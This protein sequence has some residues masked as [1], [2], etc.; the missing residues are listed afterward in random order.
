MPERS[1]WFTAGSVAVVAVCAPLATT[2]SGSAQPILGDQITV[3]ASDFEPFCTPHTVDP[4]SIP[5]EASLDELSGLVSV[6]GRSYAVGDSGSDRAVA[7]LDGSCGVTGWLSVPV[8]PYDVEDLAT[9]PDGRLWLADI[10][11]NGRR[12][13]TVALIGMDRATGAGQLH[14]LT[15]PDGAHDA[16]TV[17]VQRDGTPL[18][19]TKEV[20][21]PGIVY[22][23]AGGVSVDALA[24][25]GPT[26]LERVG[27]LD[28]AEPN[29]AGNATTGAGTTAPAVYSTMFTG[30][31]VSADGT[32]AAVRS[33]TDVFLFAAPDGD[34]A[35]ALAAGPTVRVHLPAQPQGEAVAFTED[36]DLLIASEARD[37][38]I[39]PVEVLRG[40]VAMAQDH[41]SSEAA[42]DEEKSSSAG[43]S[44]GVGAVA[45]CGLIAVVA[46]ACLRRTR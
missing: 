36:G 10:G 19:V 22:R 8:D 5:D 34:V 3:E 26:P 15:Y 27:S 14:R 11:D 43:L 31:A 9:G 29:G 23:P 18:I 25:P 45:L 30:G 17:L 2:A 32:V 28:V 7:D 41:A 20:F 33:Y 40:A 42:S 21:G 44:I 24:S 39:P 6:K 4:G 13:E 35:A 1:R 16:E 37:G 38:P 12:R 46:Y